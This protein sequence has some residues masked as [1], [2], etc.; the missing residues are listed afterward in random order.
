MPTFRKLLGPCS[1]ARSYCAVLAGLVLGLLSVTEAWADVTIGDT[2]AAVIADLGAP[3]GRLVVGARKRLSYPQGSI[4][5]V[6]GKVAAIDPAMT[7]WL[8]RRRRGEEVTIPGPAPAV[9]PRQKLESNARADST[10]GRKVET[11]PGAVGR[12]LQFS[13][14]VR[15]YGA[16]ADYFSGDIR[17]AWVNA[18]ANNK[19]SP[20]DAVADV[21]YPAGTQS[22]FLY[23]PK[24]YR[25]TEKYAVYVDI[26][27]VD[28]GGI[29][30]GY[31]AICDQHKII[32]VSP[33]AAGNDVHTARRCALALDALASLKR[34]YRIDESRVFVGGFSGGG[35][36]AA[37]LAMLYPEYFRGLMVHSR[38]VYLQPI[39]TMH[40]ASQYLW[41]SN[42]PF[43]S[44]DQIH[45]VA[46]RGLR[47]AFIS[48]TED[49]NDIHVQRSV[50]QWTGLGF[51]VKG[52]EVPG[53]GHVDAPAD[54]FSDALTWLEAAQ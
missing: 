2:E 51:A 15:M 34:A 4:T 31:D 52:F 46:G 8:E 7:A 10:S 14:S 50:T 5:M 20:E 17:Q 25:G 37:C 1:R 21:T 42:F 41:A 13:L 43:L 12:N 32:W 38:G 28:V 11:R 35:G 39:R 16:P 54:S 49:A 18:L 22:A 47:V 53:L 36:I 48:G 45:D 30:L 29:P 19:K 40:G 3:S 33:H 9:A 44:T 23:V 27:S 24:S 26:R 6:D